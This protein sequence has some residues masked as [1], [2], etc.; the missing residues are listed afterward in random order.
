MN[1]QEFLIAAIQRAFTRNTIDHDRIYHIRAPQA[2]TKGGVP[3]PAVIWRQDG[4]SESEGLDGMSDPFV[5]YFEI[6]SRSE[7]ADGAQNISQAIVEELEKRVVAVVSDFDEV[8]D[9]SQ[10]RGDY[11]AHIVEVGVTEHE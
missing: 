3:L 7:T 6:E 4:S 1:A 11:F 5:R 8:D 9:Y 2:T 10:K